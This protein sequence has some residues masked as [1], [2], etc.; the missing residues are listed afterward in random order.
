MKAE[1]LKPKL[2][3]PLNDEVGDEESRRKGQRVVRTGKRI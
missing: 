1:Y 2:F 3:K